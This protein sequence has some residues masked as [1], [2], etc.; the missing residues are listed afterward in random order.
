M[1]KIYR[2]ILV[3]VLIGINP[4]FASDDDLNGTAQ[5][6]ESPRHHA[7]PPKDMAASTTSSTAED[8]EEKQR[9][10][11]YLQEHP[12]PVLLGTRRDSNESGEDVPPVT[13]LYTVPSKFPKVQDD[14]DLSAQGAAVFSRAPSDLENFD[15]QLGS[16]KQ[17]VTTSNPLEGMDGDGI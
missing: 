4:I 12:E 5:K 3:S 8:E 14:D 15:S 6:D 7:S 10:A 2:L 13:P 9:I 11:K 17:I 1:R 16:G